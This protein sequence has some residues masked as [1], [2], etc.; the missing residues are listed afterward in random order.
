VGIG[1]AK[2]YSGNAGVG[3]CYQVCG[4][5]LPNNQCG[6]KQIAVSV[7][8]SKEYANMHFSAAVANAL[9]QHCASEF[10][11]QPPF[12]PNNVS[13]HASKFPPGDMEAL[14]SRAEAEA[15]ARWTGVKTQILKNRA[16]QLKKVQEDDDDDDDDGKSWVQCE[17]CD[18]WHTMPDGVIEWLGSFECKANNWS[19]RKADCKCTVIPKSG[20]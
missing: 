18:K 7:K 1:V 5:Q 19:K 14:V 20:R 8:G 4:A 17:K 11:D 6:G 15:A 10:E 2:T 12:K 16:D 13:I 3:C 9:L